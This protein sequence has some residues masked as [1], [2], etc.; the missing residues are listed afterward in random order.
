MLTRRTAIAAISGAAGA[1]CLAEGNSGTI[2]IPAR[3]GR[4]RQILIPAKINGSA[5]IWCL[6][7]TGGANLLYLRAAK[8]AELGIAPSSTAHSSGPL[9]TSF[10]AGGRAKVTLDAGAIHRSNQELYIKE[11]NSSDEGIV[12]AAVFADFI[13]ELDFL[14]PAVRLHPPASFRYEEHGAVFA[15]DLWSYS[16]HVQVL[17]T[18]DDHDPVKARMT[19]DS[20]AGGIADAFLTPRFN[21][22]LRRLGGSIPWV[23]D[24]QGFSTC[25][26]RRIAV[27]PFAMENPL[28]VLPPVQGFGGD[29]NA[30]DGM[31]AIN[32]LRRYRIYI[33]YA[34]KEM[35]L[36]PNS[37]DARKVEKC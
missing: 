31:L 9:D 7:D 34:K 28:I 29:A 6:L 23:P 11:F 30:P 8:A 18:I 16:P 24:K 10:R 20:G 17:L 5:E 22:E 25:R 36:E 27:G 33:D 35:I 21:D 12:G 13:V 19:V 15:I 26:I 2:E 32:F 3:L 4:N 14:R 37:P 1:S